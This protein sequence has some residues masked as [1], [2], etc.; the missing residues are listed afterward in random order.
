MKF[1]TARRS[2]TSKKAIDESIAD[3]LLSIV[4]ML[5]EEA[6]TPRSVSEL[7]KRAFVLSS[8]RDSLIKS[9]GRVNYSQV[10]TQTGLTRAEVRRVLK[11]E[12]NAQPTSNIG[13]DRG[14]RV[15]A[16][17]R[18]DRRFLDDQGRPRRLELSDGAGTFPDLVR[19]HSG[20]I[21]YRAVLDQLLKRGLATQR[22]GIVTLK[23]RKTPHGATR[24]HAFADAVPYVTAIL[25]AVAKPGS[26]LPYANRIEV[27]IPD[28]THE[29]LL[30]KRVVSGLSSL[31]A[32][33]SAVASQSERSP[34]SR[35]LRATLVLTAEPT[36]NSNGSSRARRRPLRK[37]LGTKR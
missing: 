20:D 18:S 12:A 3:L 34:A 28:S 6:Q 31:A 27:P 9:S 14:L 5:V 35:L 1:T 36:A 32:S 8:A 13:M 30:T 29:V 10:A 4:P 16:G 7:V 25:D 17:W 15:I 33:V 21:P 24:L 11:R 26:A 22:R 37:K 19:L 2:P 23:N